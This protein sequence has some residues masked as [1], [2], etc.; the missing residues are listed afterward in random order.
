[1]KIYSKKINSSFLGRCF[2]I[3][4]KTDKLRLVQLAIIQIGLALFDLVAVALVGILGA[5]TVSGFQ[6]VPPE[7][8]LH[9]FLTITNLERYNLQVQVAI[10]GCLAAVLLISRTIFSVLVTKK[11][12]YFLSMRG[13]AISVELFSRVINQPLLKIQEKSSQQLLFAVTSGVSMV[14]V[15]IIGTSINMVADIAILSILT[16][17]LFVVNPAMASGSFLFFILVGFILYRRMSSISESLGSENTNL[18]IET[19]EVALEI[20]AAYRELYVANRRQ[21]YLQSFKGLRTKSA[22]VVAQI[23]F[24]P[25]ISKYVIESLV[26]IVALLLASLQFFTQDALRAVATLSI[27]I[28]AGSR[29]TPAVLRLQQGGLTIKGAYGSAASTLELIESYEKL[30]PLESQPEEMPPSAEEFQGTLSTKELNLAYS[31]S[32]H[33]ALDKVTLRVSQGEL[34]AIVGPSGSG[35]T[36][37]VDVV[38]GILDP[39][40]GRVEI[41]GLPPIKAIQKW[42]G[43]IAYVPQ[44]VY[45]S[46]QTIRQN[47]TLG[48]ESKAFSDSQVWDAIEVAQL[49]DFVA[50]LPN[51]VDTQVGERGTKVSGGQRQRIGIARAL[52]TKPKLLVLDEATSTLDGLTERDF[53]NAIKRLHGDVTVLLIAHRLNT[54]LGA[55]RIAYFEQGKLVA[56]GN[57]S[58]VR[59]MVPNF[60]EQARIMGL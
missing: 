40:Q 9:L 36:S 15:S 59:A 2:N 4:S 12:L 24:L 41:S 8:K 13:S 19:N 38:L 23:A 39:T 55:D 52:L 32:T 45:I 10:L 48:Y 30:E 28:S 16:G 22:N 37:F 11:T 58:E 33:L 49:S 1:M 43:K 57:L 21:H 54:V 29:I 44:D 46:N 56:V 34:I 35:K 18:T 3:L 20:L 47:I 14:T 50:S 5:L 60:D 53:S 26:V 31:P 42:P 7:G 6:A 51:G 17:A 27:F 25:N